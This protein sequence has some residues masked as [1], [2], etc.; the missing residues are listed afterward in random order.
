MSLAE[1]ETH[2]GQSEYDK[3]LEKIRAAAESGATR[4]AEAFV[5]ERLKACKAAGN[6]AGEATLLTAKA[7]IAFALEDAEQALKCAREA[8]ATANLSKEKKYVECPALKAFTEAYLMK[9]MVTNA[10]RTA[11][12]FMAAASRHRSNWTDAQNKEAVGDAWQALTAVHIASA[13]AGA[14]GTIP[15]EEASTPEDAS[16][17]AKRASTTYKEAG[18]K[19]GQAHTLTLVA[20]IRLMQENPDDAVRNAQDAVEL[21]R[22]L[23]VTKGLVSALE[24]ML[25]AFSMKGDPMAGLRA[26]HGELASIKRAGDRKGEADVLQMIAQTHAMLG[27]PLGALQHARDA[28]ALYQALGNTLGE[29]WTSCTIAEM[30]RATG[31]VEGASRAA[32]KSLKLFQKTASKRGED[33][34]RK[35]LSALL[36]EQG[37]PEKAPNRKKA[38]QLLKDLVKAMHKRDVETF[39]SV[40]KELNTMGTL[41]SEA[42]LDDILHPAFAQDPSVVDWLEERGWEFE[43][44]PGKPMKITLYDRRIYYLNMIGGGGGMN[45]GPQFRHFQMGGKV[46]NNV[47]GVDA[48]AVS[49]LEEASAWEHNMKY[50]PGI[51]DVFNVVG[52]TGWEDN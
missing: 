35:T 7:E 9:G 28:L 27:E 25:Q 12:D 43:R 10:M 39:M 49:G 51:L 41:I 24:V 29:A 46:A 19:K 50:R 36:A 16:D 18:S 26:A 52:I 32:E 31:D 20:K 44:P 47:G 6:T 22:E 1:L 33:E 4:S 42:D 23:G 2:L 5:E 45:F 48:I 21:W 3:A 37:R 14:E 17:A 8:V 15:E 34:A 30:L 38:V 13:T 11:K 40:Q